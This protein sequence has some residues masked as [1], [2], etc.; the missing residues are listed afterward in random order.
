MSRSL[1][2]VCL[3]FI[4]TLFHWWKQVNVYHCRSLRQAGADK[5]TRQ[6][7]EQGR[8]R[9]ERERQVKEKVKE[10]EN[11]DLNV[12][13]VTNGTEEV[14]NENEPRASDVDLEARWEVLDLLAAEA[15][16]AALSD[17]PLDVTL[18]VVVDIS[19]S[20]KKQEDD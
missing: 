15:A 2:Q 17:E 7:S 3:S 8:P 4:N 1:R 5:L 10:E 18:F 11:E 9:R 6:V 20:R 12:T 16:A 13:R 14:E 19:E